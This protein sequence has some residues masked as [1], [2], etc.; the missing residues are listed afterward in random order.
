MD[1]RFW[2]FISGFYLFGGFGRVLIFELKFDR[3]KLSV[4]VREGGWRRGCLICRRFSF[5]LGVWFFGNLKEL[6]DGEMEGERRKE[7]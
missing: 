2:E 6:R 7:G 4:L 5:N 1:K 3:V